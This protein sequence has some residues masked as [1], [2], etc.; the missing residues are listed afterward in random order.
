MATSNVTFTGFTKDWHL[1]TRIVS[2]PDPF[3]HSLHDANVSFV[4]FWQHG[5]EMVCPTGTLRISSF[6][7][8]GR[9]YRMSSVDHSVAYR[10]ND[11]GVL[12]SSAR[13]VRRSK[14]NAD[15]HGSTEWFAVA[16]FAVGFSWGIGCT[17]APVS[18]T[19]VCSNNFT[20]CH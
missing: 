13:V 10:Q 2:Q 20:S 5:F 1:A 19:D 14:T 16:G 18:P 7:V 4:P 9:G 11:G 3:P 17:T 6:V 8:I 12:L 15:R